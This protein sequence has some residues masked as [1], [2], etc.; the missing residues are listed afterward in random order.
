MMADK[1]D[2]EGGRE[3]KRGRESEKVHHKTK[4]MFFVLHRTPIVVTKCKGDTYH[5]YIF[6]FVT[7]RI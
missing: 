3:M 6:F 5:Y 4:M 1:D 2:T 7:K